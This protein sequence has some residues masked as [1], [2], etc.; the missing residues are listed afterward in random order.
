LTPYKE[1]IAMRIMALG[2]IILLAGLGT[3][4]LAHAETWTV[5]YQRCG[6]T[7]RPTYLYVEGTYAFLLHGGAQSGPDLVLQKRAGNWQPLGDYGLV[8][9]PAGI[10]PLTGLGVNQAAGTC[11]DS[12]YAVPNGNEPP[13]ITEHYGTLDELLSAL[14]SLP[15]DAQTRAKIVTVSDGKKGQAPYILVHP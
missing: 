8:P 7:I 11:Y 14:Q 2:F 9:L 6:G 5:E 1:I 4:G 13:W 10:P 12:A 3:A 15:Y